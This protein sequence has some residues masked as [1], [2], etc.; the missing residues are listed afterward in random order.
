[1]PGLSSFTWVVKMLKDSIRENLDADKMTY[2]LWETSFHRSSKDMK[3]VLADFKSPKNNLEW[4][5]WTP[6][7]YC[8]WFQDYI[9]ADSLVQQGAK[10]HS[11]ALEVFWSPIEKSPTSISMY[12]S[13]AFLAWR[14][15]LEDQ[16]L[17]LEE[18][19]TQE[20]RQGPPKSQNW[21][22]C[23]LMQVFTLSLKPAV[24]PDHCCEWC[25]TSFERF[26]MVEIA[27][28]DILEQ[29]NPKKETMD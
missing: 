21:D 3:A 4:T 22:K 17:P 18:F 10:L 11:I 6:L 1:M 29:F 14:Q 25:E 12:S 23:S 13:A 15:L 20:L 5:G 2:I 26:S 9:A 16:Q 7:H 8:A 19:I 27:W 28:Q 24:Y